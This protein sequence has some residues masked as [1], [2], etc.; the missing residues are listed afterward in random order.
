AW[1]ICK[2]AIQRFF[3]ATRAVALRMTSILFNRA[4]LWYNSRQHRKM[5][6]PLNAPAMHKLIPRFEWNAR[7]VF[8]DSS[9]LYFRLTRELIGDGKLLVLASHVPDNQPAPNLF[10]SSVHYLLMREP[11]DA[12]P[13][14]EFFPDL[15]V[16]PN[17]TDDPYPVFR[18]FCLTHAAE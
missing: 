3:V 4:N 9:P 15:A 8:E 13:L 1:Q 18:K 6:N 2:F 7:H 5:I 12:Q 10:F 14:R 16:K 11:D 17:T